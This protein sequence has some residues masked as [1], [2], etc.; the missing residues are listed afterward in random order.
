MHSIFLSPSFPFLPLLL[1]IPFNFECAYFLFSFLFGR[2][3]V[4]SV[5]R[6]DRVEKV[7]KKLLSTSVCI[8]DDEISD[9][10]IIF[11]GTFGCIEKVC[12]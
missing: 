8:S 5:Q 4:L 2:S 12:V 10:V 9:S 6:E 1:F 3:V 7:V 11:N